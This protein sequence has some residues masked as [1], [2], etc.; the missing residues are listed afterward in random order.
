MFNLLPKD[1]KFY[2]ELEQLSDRVVS[3]AK[4]FEAIVSSFPNL[5]DNS[6]ASSR[7]VL[8]L[9]RSSASPFFGWIRPS[10][11]HWTAKT[12]SA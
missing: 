3:T 12:F 4:Q 9:A 2:D 6:A 11:L 1:D 10:S 8:Q 5:T 7:I